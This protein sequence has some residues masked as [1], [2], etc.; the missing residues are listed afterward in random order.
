MTFSRQHFSLIIGSE[1]LRLQ[2]FA[3]IILKFSWG[4]KP[5][6]SY[7]ST[8]WTDISRASGIFEGASCSKNIVLKSTPV[9][10]FPCW[11]T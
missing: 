11:P 8:T 3:K 2:D 1:V 10:I 5:P 6:L 4:G 7:R 9:F